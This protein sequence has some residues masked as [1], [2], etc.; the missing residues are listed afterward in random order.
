MD[1]SEFRLLHRGPLLNLIMRLP[2]RQDV[3]LVCFGLK[4]AR[5]LLFLEWCLHPSG[6]G[7]AS[8]TTQNSAGFE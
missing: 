1:Q 5:R 7:E 4:S 8:R 2:V 3:G 6:A